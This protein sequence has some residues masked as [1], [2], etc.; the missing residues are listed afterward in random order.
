V[1]SYLVTGAAGFIGS[2]LSVELQRRGAHVRGVDA[3]TDYYDR[4]LKDENLAWAQSLGRL[5]FVEGDLATAGLGPLL[6]GVD[7]VFHLA[8]QPGVRA[9]WGTEFDMYLRDNL[10][11]TQRVFR[12]AAAR[13]VRV[14]YASSS[15]IYGDA[16]CY[17]TPEQVPPKP[18]SPYGITKLGCEHL[19][20]S[21]ARAMRLDAVGLRYFTVFGAR[22]RPDMAFT[23]LARAAVCGDPFDLL[24][25][26]D[27]SRDF[28]YVGDA[29]A[30]TVAA[31]EWGHAGVN[32]NVGGGAE[33][34]LNRIIE[35]IEELSGS[36]LD[37]RRRARAPGDVRRTASD[38]AR[39]RRDL[40]WAPRTSIRAG[41]A[42][43]L[44]WVRSRA[45]SV[46]TRTAVYA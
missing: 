45:D 33:T 37:I 42:E 21:F 20:R 14:V 9:S 34:T 15:S 35:L 28:T 4:S 5:E 32:Y 36:A 41:L 31:M 13:G 23:R 3:F 26:G 16:E 10:L 7:G 12:A 19:A 6:D 8:A 30:A 38:T 18:I 29:V 17:P 24:G 39:I 2:H 46:P 43:Q 22:Q 40:G 27:Q 25:D 1:S 11:A 44:A